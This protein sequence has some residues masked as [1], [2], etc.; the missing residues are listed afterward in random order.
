MNVSPIRNEQNYESALERLSQILK[1]PDRGAEDEVEVLQALI[2]KWERDNHD[3][4]PPSPLEAIQFRM[5]QL[6]LKP[7]DLEPMIGPR[8]RVSEIFSGRRSL[9]LD[10]IRAL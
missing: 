2:E 9:T 10:M 7:R 3:L 6:G 1:Q 8:S 5:Q 4:P